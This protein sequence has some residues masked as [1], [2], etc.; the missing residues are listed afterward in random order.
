MKT[1]YALI[2]AALSYSSLQAS[3][4]VLLIIADDLG[5]NGVGFHSRSMSTP[6]LDRL[7]KDGTELQR[8][9]T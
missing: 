5:W 7:A 1:F 6:N 4:N 8:Y 2:A 3:P 9:Y